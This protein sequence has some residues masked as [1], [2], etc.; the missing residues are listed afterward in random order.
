M[1]NYTKATDFAAKDALASGNPNKVVKGTEIDAEFEAIETALSTKANTA[2]PTFTGTTTIPTAD[3]NGGAIDATAIGASSASTGAFT[4][5][6]ASGDLTA[7]NF[8]GKNKIMNGNFDIWQRGFGPFTSA[9]YTADRWAQVGSS[10]SVSTSLASFTVGQTAVPNEPQHYLRSV[11]TTASTSSSYIALEQRIESVRTFAGQTATLSFYAKADASKNIAVEFDQYFGTGG[12]PSA[13]VT[14]IGVTTCALTTSWQKFEV[15]VSIPSIS[16][17]TLGSAGGDYL[18][19][20]LWFEGGLN[21]NAQTNSL[22]NQSGTFDIAQV[23]LEKGSSATQFETRSYGQELALC[24]RYYELCGGISGTAY[25][26][27]ANGISGNYAYNV[28]KRAPAT[29]NTTT[30]P[31]FSNSSSLTAVASTTT[32][33]GYYVLVTSTGSAS[34]GLV[35]S[36]VISADCEL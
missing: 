3:I 33:F 19:M 11:V 25:N 12:S 18:V 27:T 22:G 21:F 16:G 31:D 8:L 30:A 1:S 6:A 23:Q 32:G 35:T 2:S 10:S 26:I 9:E 15:T 13:N 7:N 28:T 20:R 5:L 4:T 24:Q 14:S 29:L 34:F 17:K 36:G